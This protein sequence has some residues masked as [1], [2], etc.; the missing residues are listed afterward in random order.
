MSFSDTYLRFALILLH[1]IRLVYWMITERQ[2]HKEKP[3]KE[4]RG[5]K[6]HI[7]IL[8]GNVIW[9][10]IIAQLL[11]LQLFPYAHNTLFQQIGFVLS[12]IGIAIAMLGRKGLGSNWTHSGEYQIKKGQEL[13]STGIYA[14]IRHPIYGGLI[15]A[16]L[17]GELVAESYLAVPFF[18]LFLLL[19]YLQGRNEEKILLHHFGKKYEEYMKHT[20]MF[21]PGLV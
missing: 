13:I 5:S 2:A 20:K 15:L 12:I 16:S 19:A 14:Y 10:V 7:K 6:E 8:V 17:G 18:L 4:L 21:F 11:G 3:K 1:F 9:Y